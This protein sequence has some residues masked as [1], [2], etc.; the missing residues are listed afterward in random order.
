MSGVSPTMVICVC[1]I[2][3]GLISMI[4][5]FLVAMIISSLI[6]WPLCRIIKAQGLFRLLLVLAP[7]DASPSGG[8]PYSASHGIEAVCVS[9]LELPFSLKPLCNPPFQKARVDEADA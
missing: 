8:V 6:F 9:A 3:M 4:S 5:C 1:V 2:S 7:P